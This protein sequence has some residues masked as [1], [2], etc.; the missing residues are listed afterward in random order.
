MTKRPWEMIWKEGTTCRAHKA[1]WGEEKKQWKEI[2][3]PPAAQSS[4][5]NNNNNYA[6]RINISP[7]II[8]RPIKMD[9]CDYHACYQH[10]ATVSQ[11]VLSFTFNIKTRML[12]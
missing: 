5:N 1:V 12:L 6:Q 9:H 3:T 2:F 8:S 7:F 11:L 10:E 4:Y